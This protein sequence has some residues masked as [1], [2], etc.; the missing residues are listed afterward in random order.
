MLHRFL[1]NKGVSNNNTE[2]VISASQQFIDMFEGVTE[3]KYKTSSQFIYKEKLK[4]SGNYIPEIEEIKTFEI[5]VIH[6]KFQIPHSFILSASDKYRSKLH[7]LNNTI[8]NINSAFEEKH[9]YR[10]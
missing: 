9:Q 2:A 4:K 1:L 8:T 5:A 6:Q 10:E 3:D 7:K